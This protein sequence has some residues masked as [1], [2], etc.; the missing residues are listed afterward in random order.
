MTQMGTTEN[1]HNNFFLGKKEQLASKLRNNKNTLTIKLTETHL[2]EKIL[3]SE[4]QMRNCIRFRA[5][6]TLGRKNGSVITC[7]KATEEVG[8]DRLIAKSNS[9][10][11][12]QLIRIQNRNIVFI[13]VCRPPNCPTEKFTS[14]LNVLR[15]KLIEIGNPMPYIIFNGD[16]NFSIIDWQIE[17]A[18]CGT[19]EN[20][21]QAKNAFPQFAHTHTHTYIYIYI[22]CIEEPTRKNN[23]L[24]SRCLSH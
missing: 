11:E 18:D 2:N 16:L 17:I 4:I 21:L 9:Y 19:H 7:I 14:P 12:Y 1:D 8:A 13:N 5:D 15:T 23:I 6:R 3:D 10:L 22:I 24:E 20:Q